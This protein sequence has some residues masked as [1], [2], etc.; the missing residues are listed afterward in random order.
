[1]YSVCADEESRV[2]IGVQML[3]TSAP[4]RLCLQVAGIELLSSETQDI[5]KIFGID[6]YLETWLQLNHNGYLVTM[7]RNR[8]LQELSLAIH[9]SPRNIE[10]G[11][12]HE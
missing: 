4:R 7:G 2:E 12:L 1:M 8:T 6:G 11:L 10:R 3:K 5:N 9:R